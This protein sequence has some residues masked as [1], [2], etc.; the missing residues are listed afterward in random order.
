M[1]GGPNHKSH[2]MTSLEIFERG[3][4][5]GQR[6]RRMEDQM[7]PGLQGL[8]LNQDFAE[9]RGLKPKVKTSKLED[10]LSKVV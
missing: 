3:T 9:G 4:F 6:Y 5:V 8:A 7:P 1:K 10:V 2:T